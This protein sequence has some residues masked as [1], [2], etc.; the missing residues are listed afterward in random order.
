MFSIPRC[1]MFALVAVLAMAIA[2][3]AAA[4]PNAHKPSAGGSIVVHGHWTIVVRNRAG[5]I[6]SRRSFENEYLP[7]AGLLPAVLGRHYSVGAWEVIVNGS[8]C[9]CG[10]EESGAQYL[11]GRVVSTNLKVSDS[12]ESLV[13]KGDVSSTGAGAITLVT[14]TNYL[15]AAA[16]PPSMP[17]CSWV[18]SRGFTAKSLSSPVT[19]TAAGQD[20]AVTVT[21][22]F[23]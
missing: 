8:A 1:R 4:R 2:P 13:L 23:S 17:D 21:F 20:I 18:A 6:V 10:I 3:A 22:T 19:V 12:G 7:S 16:V 14:T 5:R 15:C 9:S 11:P